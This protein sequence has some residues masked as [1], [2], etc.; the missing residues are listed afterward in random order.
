MLSWGQP[1]TNFVAPV[2]SY[3]TSVGSS[4][5]F[6]ADPA[7]ASAPPN[8]VF[9][10]AGAAIALANI[11]DGSSNTVAFG[12]WKLGTGLTSVTIPQD[13][14]FA[15]TLPAGITRNTPTMYMPAGWPATVSWLETCASIAATARAEKTPLCGTSWTFTLPGIT[16]GNLVEPPNPKYLYCTSNG[17]DCLMSLA[18]GA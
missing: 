8:G 17:A 13:I 14:I 11:T 9:Q 10:D 3:F 6:D 5:E 4:L 18:C 2:N 1:L 7:Y 16:L 15:G 12:E